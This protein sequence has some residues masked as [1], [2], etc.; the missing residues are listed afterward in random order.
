MKRF[1]P[2]LLIILVIGAC[3][4]SIPSAVI[5]NDA[6]KEAWEI[7]LVEMRIDR[8]E[9][10]MD[11]AQTP[12]L[13]ADQEGFI[14]LNYYYP[15]ESLR[16]ITKFEKADSKEVV[17]L[18]KRTGKKVE[19][20]RKG[21]VSFMHNDEAHTLFAYGP[22]DTT[23][24]GDYLWL[25]FFDAGTAT[26]SYAGGRYMDLEIAED[27]TVELDFNFAYNPLCAYNTEDYNCTLPP[28]D[29]RLNFEVT[30]GEKTF[31]LEQ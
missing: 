6:E 31:H 12:L 24:Y 11:P 16:F 23:K 1:L 27:G 13:S 3:S 4:P 7:R 30:A 8:N 19:Y 15:D 5:M 29:N 25:P 26:E 9:K 21:S 28:A 18:E 10:F 17:V 2:L 22:V 20:L 14:G